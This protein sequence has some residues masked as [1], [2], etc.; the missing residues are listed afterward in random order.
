M[1]LLP[2][3][4]LLIPRK[5][6]DDS[7]ASCQYRVCVAKFGYHSNILIPLRNTIL[8]WRDYLTLTDA[9][10]SVNSDYR[11]LGFGWGERVWYIDPPTQLDRQI[12]YGARALLLPN[13][14][15]LKVQRYR[16]L[17]QYEVIKCVGVSRAKYLKLIEFIKQSFQRD[18]QGNVIRVAEA[19]QWNATFYE[20]KGTYSVLNNSNHWTARG[21]RIA[22]INTPLWAGHSAAI[23]RILES[24]CQ[25]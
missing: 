7:Q 16:S 22:G 14:S 15:A 10:A 2:A 25:P 9:D 6:H 23:A 11:Y 20:A 1:V 21:L 5:W 17:P 8:Y 12:L 3:I 4:G 18:K 24:N 13:S 19:P